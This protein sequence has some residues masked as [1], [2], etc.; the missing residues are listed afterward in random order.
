M[1]TSSIIFLVGIFVLTIA[2]FLWQ[3]FDEKRTR[4]NEQHEWEQQRAQK[5]RDFTKSHPY[6]S[7]FFYD[8]Q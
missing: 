7:R 5:Q 6:L 4:L 3:H 2:F 1:D 8:E